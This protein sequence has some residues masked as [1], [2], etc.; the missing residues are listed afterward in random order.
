MSLP[1]PP[2][3]KGKSVPLPAPC[4][5]SLFPLLPYNVVLF[6]D[7]E[8]GLLPMP[9]GDE[10]DRDIRVRCWRRVHP[11]RVGQGA[12]SAAKLRRGDRN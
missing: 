11:Y 10:W 5:L 8:D 7:V 4:Q 12:C 2:S 6:E 3:G 1:T 9:S